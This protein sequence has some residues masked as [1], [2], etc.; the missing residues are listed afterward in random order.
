M[1]EYDFY[2]KNGCYYYYYTKLSA[3]HAGGNCR[4]N[5]LIVVQVN[6]NQ[7][8]SM[9]VIVDKCQTTVEANKEKI[10]YETESCNMV[11]AKNNSYSS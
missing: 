6:N 2:F 3:R 5:A 9:V 10:I 8:K 7:P 4:E 11:T 1:E